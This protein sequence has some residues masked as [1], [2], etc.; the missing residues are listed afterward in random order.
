MFSQFQFFKIGFARKYEQL[1]LC[2]VW[3]L[4][5]NFLL[6]N[7]MQSKDLIQKFYTNYIEEFIEKEKLAVPAGLD[8]WL[9]FD[10]KKKVG[11]SPKVC[12]FCSSKRVL[13][14]VKLDTRELGLRDNLYIEYY[15]E[16]CNSHFL[17]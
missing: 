8:E 16:D 13:E 12:P 11:V 3:G 15:C 7:N 10:Y 5:F 4:N 1:V 2:F 17:I 14:G 6:S 9:K